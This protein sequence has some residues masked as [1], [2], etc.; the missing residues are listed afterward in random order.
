MMLISLGT[1]TCQLKELTSVKTYKPLT[2]SMRSVN[3]HW[4]SSYLTRVMRLASSLWRV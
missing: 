2:R 1:R 4:L 3:N